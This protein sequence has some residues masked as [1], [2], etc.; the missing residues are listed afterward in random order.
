MRSCYPGVSLSADRT[1]RS[2]S[3]TSTFLEPHPDSRS[4]SSSAD[5]AFAA[6]CQAPADPPHAFTVDLGRRIE[7]AR[8][9]AKPASKQLPR[10]LHSGIIP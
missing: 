8:Y 1:W 10:P 5:G 9:V 6:V 7:S 3:R 4:V 2:D